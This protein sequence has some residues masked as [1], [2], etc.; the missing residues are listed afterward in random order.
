MLDYNMDARGSY[1]LY[2]YLYRC[3]RVDIEMGVIA[4][5]EHLPSKRALAEHLGI[6]VITV[7]NAYAQLVAEGYLYSKPRSGFYAAVLPERSKAHLVKPTRLEVTQEVEQAA[8]DRETTA[9]FSA[10]AARLWSQA[11]RSAL[12]LESDSELYTVSPSQG[13]VRL[14]RALAKHLRQTRGMDVNPENIVVGAGA[15][16]LD[17]ML[18]QL[19]GSNCIWALED[20]GYTRLTSLYKAM[21]AHVCHIALDNEG[22]LIDK[23]VA[24]DADVV[25]IMPS[26]QFPT[27]VVTSITRRYG[28]LSWASARKGRYIIEDDY[29]CEFR[30][31][32]KPIPSF[33][34]IDAAG[35]V[36]Y[37]NTF[38]RSLS[39]A[40]RL[41][42]MVLPDSLMEKYRS[43]LSFYSSTVSTVQQVALAR[44]LET[45]DYER[46]VNRMRKQAREKRDALVNL[47]KDA[48]PQAVIEAADAGLHFVV[49][50]PETFEPTSLMQELE[51]NDA[52]VL[53]FE[54]CLV[55]PSNN[56]AS[57]GFMRYIVRY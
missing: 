41:A 54:S 32:G 39:G 7:E 51:R 46:H 34:S 27:G 2:E 20:P 6:S 21:G 49:A 8:S 28:L 45:G 38:S 12:T 17:I 29:D 11:L 35:S 16:V 48:A 53:P 50:L 37:T 26:H 19:I 47:I 5:D 22:I 42:Y 24:S 33:Q 40:L 10:G 57:D 44:L 31:A 13:I 36:I 25:H 52:Q 15:Q 18:V 43:E 56:R 23:L 14:R 55:E 1:S 3:I 4:A 9:L 30:L